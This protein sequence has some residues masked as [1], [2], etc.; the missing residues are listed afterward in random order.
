M[1]IDLFSFMTEILYKISFKKANLW[2]LWILL[3]A[4][5]KKQVSK[6]WSKDMVYKMT[7]CNIFTHHLIISISFSLKVS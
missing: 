1:T 2:S 6:I 3:F 4:E 7:F 5:Q